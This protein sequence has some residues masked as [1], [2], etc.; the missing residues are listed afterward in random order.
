[1]F[2]D[3]HP[4]LQAYRQEHG[5]NF[6]GH[7]PDMASAR[8]PVETINQW[9]GNRPVTQTD[10]DDFSTQTRRTFNLMVAT[11]TV[12]GEVNV[13]CDRCRKEVTGWNTVQGTS[14]FYALRPDDSREFPWASCFGPDE[15]IIC[16]ACMYADPG[17]IAAYGSRG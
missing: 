11:K 6:T 3:D 7:G 14:N 12:L 15:V 17:Y 8:R 1:M 4:D 2:C 9:S 16:D 10:I 5:L 13:V